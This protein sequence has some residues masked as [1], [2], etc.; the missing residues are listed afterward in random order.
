MNL[1][2][3]IQ[4]LDARGISLKVDAGQI[5]VEK[6]EP[7]LGTLAQGFDLAEFG[8]LAVNVQVDWLEFFA[9]TVFEGLARRRADKTA[10]R[11]AAP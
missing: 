2:E 8:A 5:A 4:E 7:G 3:K 6:Y 9:Q 1:I 11:A 10:R